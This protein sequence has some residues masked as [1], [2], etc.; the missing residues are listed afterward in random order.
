MST[1]L[2]KNALKIDLNLK[3]K[4]YN[5]SFIDQA[6]W[7]KMA[8]AGYWPCFVRFYGPRLETVNTAFLAGCV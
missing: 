2:S 1:C 3:V 7:V 4:P 8:M 5:K 6:C